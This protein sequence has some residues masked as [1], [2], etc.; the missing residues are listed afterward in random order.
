M[1]LVTYFSQFFFPFS[2]NNARKPAGAIKRLSDQNNRN[3]KNLALTTNK[4]FVKARP[5][6]LKSSRVTTPTAKVGDARL[7]IIQKQRQKITD[8]REKL[9][10]IAKQTDARLRLM[11]MRERQRPVVPGRLQDPLRGIL[12][13]EHI[14]QRTIR[15]PTFDDAYIARSF[16]ERAVIDPDAY[17]Y[18]TR[19]EPPL[20]YRT[21]EN[22]LPHSRLGP[23]PN[24]FR[25]S[26]PGS[27]SPVIDDVT[28]IPISKL[29]LR[30]PQLLSINRND[31]KRDFKLN[32]GN[33]ESDEPQIVIT[34]KLKPVECVGILKR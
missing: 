6:V 16:S 33:W 12:P 32:S 10:Q 22:D 2:A 17:M 11:K 23:E 21:I 14:L 4:S 20:L 28:D 9:G 18:R 34:K 29:G 24:V 30:T 7:K 8:A 25:W 19:Q 5:G 1:V 31:N 15:G 27:T 13:E 26:R 3:A